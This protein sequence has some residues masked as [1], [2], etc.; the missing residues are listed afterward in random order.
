MVLSRA[1]TS[2]TAE[3]QLLTHWLGDWDNTVDAGRGVQSDDST[4]NHCNIQKL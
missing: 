3:E 2:N 4:V 1:Y